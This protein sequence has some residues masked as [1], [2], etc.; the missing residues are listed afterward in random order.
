[1]AFGKPHP[2]AFGT[3]TRFLGRYV[4]E[5]KIMS[6][7]EGVRK[8]TGLPA[9]KLGLTSRGLIKQ[10]YYADLVV[11]DPATVQDCAT[12]ADP[13]QYSQGID[14]VVVNGRVVLDQ[15]VQRDVFA[16]RIVSK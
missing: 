13:K 12:Y 9:K 14:T 15:G 3:P 5:K 2:R 7:E 1:M 8:M 6:F 11:F 10:G 4:R 16:G